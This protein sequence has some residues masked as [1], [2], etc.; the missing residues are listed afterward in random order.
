MR[1]AR[2]VAA[3]LALLSIVLAV[4][5]I[6]AGG[7][8]SKGGYAQFGQC[9]LEDSATDLCL[10]TQTKGGQFAVG[11]ETVPIGRTVTLQGG[12]H[13]VENKE[14]EIVKEEFIGAKNGET[15][16]DAPQAVPGGL[17]GV[18]DPDLLPAEPREIFDR[19]VD[20]GITDV[21]ATIEL[22]APASS[23]GID[24]QDLVEAQGIA[25]SLPVKVKLSNAFLGAGCYIGSDAHPISLPLTTGETHPPSP[26]RPIKGKVGRAK[27]KDEYNL[28]VIRK[29]SLVNNAFA[30]PQAK[31]CGGARSPL[32]DPAV[33]AKLGLPATSGH[34][35][36]ILDGTLQDVNAMAV[37]AGK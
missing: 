37:R 10:Y 25:L 1:R 9:P 31:G 19:L 11:D 13:V 23:I 3:L 21:T 20:R 18:V 33:N 8:D 26:N 7:D 22:A 4:S 17:R 24:I 28:T 30:A 29:S 12:V 35:T 6:V 36:A 5:V 16:S 34:N 2:T 15:V 32:I 14:K 27:I